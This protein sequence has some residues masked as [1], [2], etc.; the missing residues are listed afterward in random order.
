MS[1]DSLAGHTAKTFLFLLDNMSL[2]LCLARGRSR[3]FKVLVVLRRIYAYCLS[4]GIMPYFR[5]IVSE[6][7]SSDEPSRVL[8]DKASELATEAIEH[9]RFRPVAISA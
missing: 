4:R 1:R 3:N 5:W 6:L 8:G 7:N 2:V 9:L